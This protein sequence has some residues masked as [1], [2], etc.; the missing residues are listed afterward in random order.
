MVWADSGEF[1]SQFMQWN[2]PPRLRRVPFWHV[3]ILRMFEVSIYEGY[4]KNFYILTRRD[5]TFKFITAIDFT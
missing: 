2:D 3:S 4:V 5:T 1:D